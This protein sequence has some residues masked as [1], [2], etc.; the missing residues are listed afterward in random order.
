MGLFSKEKC[1]ICGKEAGA[2]NRIKIKSGEF[3][4]MDCRR[5]CH[6]FV[7]I[8]YLTKEQVE[9]QI[10]EL[11]NT[12]TALQE[13]LNLEEVQSDYERLLSLTAQLEEAQTTLDALYEEWAELQEELC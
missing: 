2:L 9:A 8:A 3:I 11:E 5:K 10:E 13:E 4:C 6:P 1:F 12:I 7:H